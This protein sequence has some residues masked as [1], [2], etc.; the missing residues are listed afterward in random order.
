MGGVVNDL[1]WQLALIYCRTQENFSQTPFIK[2]QAKVEICIRYLYKLIL[3]T[4]KGFFYE[5]NGH[6]PFIYVIY[7]IEGLFLQRGKI[8]NFNK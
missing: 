8:S 3:V 1:Y 6:Q 4:I 7:C 5:I 2:F